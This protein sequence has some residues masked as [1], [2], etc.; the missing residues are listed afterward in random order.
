MI[1]FFS[2][3]ESKEAAI[4]SF[5]LT[6]TEQISGVDAIPP[7]PAPMLRCSVFPADGYQT[8]TKSIR[9]D[10]EINK[11]SSKFD[12]QIKH[13]NFAATPRLMYYPVRSRRQP[14]YCRA[15]AGRGSTG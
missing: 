8:N 11:I 2:A 13:R 7:L 9:K 12:K 5:C 3:I 4:S 1:L 6:P 10:F 15:M 14:P